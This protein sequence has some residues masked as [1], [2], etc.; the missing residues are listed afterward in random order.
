M[1]FKRPHFS[2]MSEQE[3]I[4]YY[5][6]N[7]DKNCVG[8]LYKRYTSF[9]FSICLKYLKNKDRAQETTLEIFELLMDK[10]L[11]FEIANFRSWLHTTTK[12]YCLNL[13]R[14]KE[15]SVSIEDNKNYFSSFIMEEEDVLHPIKKE[16]QLILLEKCINELKPEQ[17]ECIN[18]F[19]LQNKSYLEVVE[20]SGHPIKKVKSFIQNG[21]RNLKLLMEKSN[22]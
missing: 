7:K 4:C 8:E 14:K 18:L 6:Q 17:K 15:Y 9:V 22:E 1:L 11:E 5:K 20:I 10:L 13:L 16:K 2:K 3:L 12:N 21:K 19:Y